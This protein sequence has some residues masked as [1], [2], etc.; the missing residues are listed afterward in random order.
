MTFDTRT[1]LELRVGR[2]HT[3]DVLLH[4]R[5]SDVKWFHSSADNKKELFRLLSQHIIFRE[6]E[7]EIQEFHDVRNGIRP[8]VEVGEKNKPKAKKGK[9]RKKG[10]PAEPSEP[11]EKPKRD[12]RHVFGTGIQVTYK[13]EEVSDKEGASLIFPK[14]ATNDEKKSNTK[15]PAPKFRQL[16]KLSKRIVLWCYPRDEATDDSTVS[17]A[18]EGQGFPRPE[19]V[20]ITSL[21]REPPTERKDG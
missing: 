9:K 18:P 13:T 17:P 11:K 14:S 16:P 20:P 15:G 3:V 4:L 19:M 2:T 8:V 12:I 21:F 6:C 10:E 1:F 7:K 5:R